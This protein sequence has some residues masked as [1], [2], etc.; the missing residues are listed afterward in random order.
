MYNIWWNQFPN[1]YHWEQKEAEKKT[2]KEHDIE[3]Q[4]SFSWFELKQRSRWQ[5]VFS[6]LNDSHGRNNEIITIVEN[7]VIINMF[8]TQ[9]V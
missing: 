7:G 4:L 3:T 8:E 1:T 5:K 9:N 6:K 2:M